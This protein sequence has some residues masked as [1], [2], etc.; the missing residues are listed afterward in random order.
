MSAHCIGFKL[1][2]NHRNPNGIVP[3]SW[4]TASASTLHEGI[5]LLMNLFP[6]E[7]RVAGRSDISETYVDT[8]TT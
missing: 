5:G 1:Y 4:L 6:M 7:F 2:A 3:E 8:L